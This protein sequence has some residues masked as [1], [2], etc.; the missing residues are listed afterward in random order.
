LC[1]FGVVVG[2]GVA[3]GVA[4]VLGGVLTSSSVADDADDVDGV[5]GE[6]V[7]AEV[8][9]LLDGDGET[10]GDGET[11]GEGDS[12][13]DGED[14]GG[15][16][17]ALGL[18][19]LEQLADGVGPAPPAWLGLLDPVVDGAVAD[20]PALGPPLPPAGWPLPAGWPPPP[21]LMCSAGPVLLDP[22]IVKMLVVPLVSASA[23]EPRIS[24]KAA[25]AATGR[26]QR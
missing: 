15:P 19:V 22:L 2:V 6:V 7:P 18:G 12:E 13:G 11:V 3:V 24:T 8:V 23:P 1:F 14:V 16:T 4:L 21:F 10:E 17:E 20:P 25:I 5:G 26:S 9:G